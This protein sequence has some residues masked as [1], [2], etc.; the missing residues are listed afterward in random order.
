[1]FPV[2]YGEA[3]G[4][5]SLLQFV[6]LVILLFG[7]AVYNGSIPIFQ[8]DDYQSL[9][10]EDAILLETELAMAPVTLQQ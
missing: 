3:W 9:E 2:D 10:N 7:T 8:E 4:A 6:G 1:M 5:G